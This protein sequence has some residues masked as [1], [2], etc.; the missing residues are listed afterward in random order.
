MPEL[1]TEAKTM[2]PEK[3]II[4]TR[5]LKRLLIFN[6]F[7]TSHNKINH[8]KGLTIFLMKKYFFINSVKSLSLHLL[9][10]SGLLPK[11]FISLPV[12]KLE[13]LKNG[14]F[15]ILKITHL[16]VNL[17]ISVNTLSG[18]SKCSSTSVFITKSKL[19]SGY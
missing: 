9:I 11:V 19:L 10:C 12:R 3:I 4:H 6:L 5:N 14:S 1:S 18:Y 16:F 13:R 15:G 2:R 7:Q 17:L 8:G